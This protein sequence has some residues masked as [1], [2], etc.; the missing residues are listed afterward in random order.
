MKISLLLK[1]FGQK[2][3]LRIGFHYQH[4]TVKL[5]RLYVYSESRIFIIPTEYEHWAFICR[6]KI[7]L[8]L[9]L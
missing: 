3:I 7:K 2:S 9:E 4:I 6:Y 1:Y 8:T 5:L